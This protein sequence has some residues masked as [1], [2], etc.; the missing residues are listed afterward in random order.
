MNNFMRQLKEVGLKYPALQPDI[1]EIYEIAVC[2]IEDGESESNEIEIG[3][4]ALD[5]LVEEHIENNP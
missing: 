3:L 5:D 1:Q 4:S 2:E